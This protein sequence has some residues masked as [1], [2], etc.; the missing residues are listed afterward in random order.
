MFQLQEV[1]AGLLAASGGSLAA[2]GAGAA[3]TTLGSRAHPHCQAVPI[4]SRRYRLPDENA[5]F[6]R[7][8]QVFGGGSLADWRTYYGTA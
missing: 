2:R 7:M 6:A 8:W 5:K 1:L 4:F 3:P